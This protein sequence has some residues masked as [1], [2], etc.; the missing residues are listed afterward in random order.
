MRQRDLDQPGARPTFST[1]RKVTTARSAR[2][3]TVRARCSHAAAGEP[4]GGGQE[5]GPVHVKGREE[6]IEIYRLA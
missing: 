5:L 2:R 3:H 4:P 6:P 1:A